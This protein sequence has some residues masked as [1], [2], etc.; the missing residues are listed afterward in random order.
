MVA[1][2]RCV[3]GPSETQTGRV[4]KAVLGGSAGWSRWRGQE[5]A[6]EVR[7]MLIMLCCCTRW[8]GEPRAGLS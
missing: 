5:S 1:A 4:L 8:E 3:L 7:V 2:L 6:G